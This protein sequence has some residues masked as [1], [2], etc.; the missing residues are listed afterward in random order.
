MY[1]I[2]PLNRRAAL[3]LLLAGASTLAF[4]QPQ[5]ARADAAPVDLPKPGPRDT[6]AVCGMFVARYP[7]WVATVVFADGTTFYFD[8]PKDFFKFLEDVPKYAAGRSRDQIATMGVTDY[9]GVR[10]VAAAE[11]LFAVGSDV[12]GPMGHEFVPLATEA[13]AADFMKDHAGKH[14]FRFAEIPAGLPAKL[15]AGQFE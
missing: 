2:T 12:L 7:E 5:P 6:C 10:Q 1:N 13:D 14:L 8:G 11:A 4:A 15:D 3:S 9:Y